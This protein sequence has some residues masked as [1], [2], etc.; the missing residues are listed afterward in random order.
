MARV[1][2]RAGRGAVLGQGRPIAGA[3]AAASGC[4]GRR[5]RE[6]LLKA[7]VEVEVEV[8]DP[9]KRA[10]ALPRFSLSAARGIEAVEGSL[11][12]RL[13]SEDRGR[14]REREE[15]EPRPEPQPL[16]VEAGQGRGQAL[17]RAQA[18]AG[19]AHGDQVARI[20]GIGLD[21]APQL[22]DVDVDRAGLDAEVARVAPDLGQQL[23]PRHCPLTVRPEVLEE[24]DL[25]AREAERFASLGSARLRESTCAS[26]PSRTSADR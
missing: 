4:R 23:F 13:L 17:L 22:R 16:A 1:R 25:P 3:R 12:D 7:Q 26:E 14:Q 6:V 18:V 11:A 21:L 5:F 20:G 8:L 10:W 2:V 15:E 9:T 24:L 19:S